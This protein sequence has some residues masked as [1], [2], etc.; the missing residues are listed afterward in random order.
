MR[1]TVMTERAPVAGP[2]AWLGKDMAQSPRWVR[3]LDRPALAAIDAGLRHA[4]A[5]GVEW[6][7]TT[8][9]TFPLPGREALFQDVAEE[10]EDGVGILKLRGLPVERYSADELKTIWFG[11]GSHLGRPVYQNARGE[12][13][14]EIRDEG[15]E[16]GKRYGELKG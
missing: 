11:I 8:A 2:C 15:A 14:R 10:L 3:T 6:S 1:L 4:Q 5:G 16:V 9:E 13:M 7:G 12:L